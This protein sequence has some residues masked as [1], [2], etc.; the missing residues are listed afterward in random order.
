[1]GAVEPSMM[2]KPIRG[3]HGESVAVRPGEGASF[4][5]LRMN[6]IVPLMKGDTAKPGG[7]S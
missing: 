2:M 4:D 1:M 6:G 3:I 5:K 7:I